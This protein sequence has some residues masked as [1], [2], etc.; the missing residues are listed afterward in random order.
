MTREE[1]DEIFGK[2]RE[3]KDRINRIY[4]AI[5]TNKGQIDECNADLQRMRSERPRNIHTR[6]GFSQNYW[7]WQ[8]IMG[9]VQNSKSR[10]YYENTNLYSEA[11]DLK[12]QNYLLYDKL[13]GH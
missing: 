9:N 6:S 4:A 12:A 1:R 5:S 2:I 7:D 3:N 10:F 13:K 11:N 8:E